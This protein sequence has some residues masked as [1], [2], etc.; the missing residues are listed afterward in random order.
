M[1]LNNLN[2]IEDA[3]MDGSHIMI[4][5]TEQDD[6]KIR[7]SWLINQHTVEWEYEMDCGSLVVI[8]NIL[9]W[10]PIPSNFDTVAS[11]EYVTH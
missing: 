10:F 3:P 5:F 2:D 8:S 4:V 11:D 1:I 7:E 6:V 9:G